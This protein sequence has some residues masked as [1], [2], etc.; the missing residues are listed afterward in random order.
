MAEETV[1]KTY[2]QEAAEAYQGGN[3]P[4]PVDGYDGYQTGISSVVNNATIKPKEAVVSEPAK[5]DFPPATNS[6]TLKEP[7]GGD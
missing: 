5:L 4:K 2:P 3:L 6:Q 7:K 1:K